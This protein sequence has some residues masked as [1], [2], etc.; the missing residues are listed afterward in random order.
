MIT[1]TTAPQDNEQAILAPFVAAARKTVSQPAI[2]AA[3]DRFRSGLPRSQPRTRRAGWRLAGASLVMLAAV[4][5]APLLLPD[6]GGS[7]FAEV[8]RWFQDFQSAHIRTEIHQGQQPVVELDVWVDSRG[9]ARIENG[10]IV[11]I[12]AT[13]SGL[14]H[15]LLPGNQVVTVPFDATAAVDDPRAAF[16]WLDELRDFQGSAELLPRFRVV[17]GVEAAGFVL[18]LDET[19]I[20]LWAATDDNRPILIEG[21][22]PGGLTMR[23]VMD[24]DQ[25][26][27]Q[28]VFEVPHQYRALEGP[29]D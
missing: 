9:S 4:A 23:S 17:N 1:P 28:G 7:A 13:D 22:L 26:L 18:V 3:A 6:Q 27:P 21:D 5:L 2:D 14:L 11:T 25:P 10:T 19:S 16:R 12:L 29:G 20:T 15:T 24:F 8:Q